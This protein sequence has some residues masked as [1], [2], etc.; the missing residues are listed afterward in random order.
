MNMSLSD[1]CRIV[2]GTMSG[3]DARFSSVSI[4]TRSLQRGDLFVA[5]RGEHFDA[6]DF[7]N[8]AVEKGSVGA[9]IGRQVTSEL[10]TIRVKDTRLALGRLAREWRNSCNSLVIGVT[11]SNGKT[12]VK[13]MIASILGLNGRVLFTQGNL[14]NE[15]GVPLTLLRLDQ[16]DQYAV[17]EM[18]ANHPGEIAYSSS[19]AEPDVAVLTNA[20]SAHLEGFCSLQGVASAKGELVTSLSDD[21]VAILN[22]DD[23]FFEYW[24]GLAGNARVLSFGLGTGANIRATDI[25]MTWTPAGVENRFNLHLGGTWRSIRLQVAGTHNVCNALAAAAAAQA[26]GI[27][28]DQIGE[29]LENFRSV[30]G[31]VQPVPGLAG[32][33][34]IDDTYNANP[35]SF[36]AAIEVLAQFKGERCV[37]LGA[38]AE[39]GESSDELHK[40][41]GL[42]AR[43][44]GISRFFATGEGAESAVD[45]FGDGAR[46][47]DCQ[48][49]LIEASRE[50]LSCHIVVLVKGSRSQK[51]DRVV[52]ALRFSESN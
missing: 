35:S 7:L 18:G 42:H 16:G 44:Q 33:L 28:M 26:I 52:E 15:I 10:P 5:I 6:H 24:R 3:P 51:M 46:F 2:N 41:V 50:L 22:A 9:I 45:A 14:N 4:N 38:F 29:G 17:V 19:L 36:E 21:G 34:L 13:E 1:T 48:S 40:Q 39:L 20:G 25:E 43:N 47:F 37:V 23:R 12:T 27:N 8:I 49:D 31:R 11:G 32:S 30:Q